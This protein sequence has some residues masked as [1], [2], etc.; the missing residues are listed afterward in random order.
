MK[1]FNARLGVLF[2]VLFSFVFPAIGFGAETVPSPGYLDLDGTRYVKIP[3]SNDFAIPAGGTMTITMR[4][5]QNFSSGKETLQSFVSTLVVNNDN[6]VGFDIYNLLSGSDF[7]TTCNFRSKSTDS[8]SY[9][10]FSAPNAN[11]LN[12][13]KKDIHIAVVFSNDEI[14]ANKS[15]VYLYSNGVLLGKGNMD[16]L[17]IPA[18]EALLIGARYL[19]ATGKDFSETEKEHFFN[20]Q[21]DEV[22]FY[23]NAL[24]QDE[25]KQ[26]MESK[27]FISGK[28]ILAAYDFSDLSDGIVRDIS[29]KEHHGKLM[30]S[31]PTYGPPSQ[32]TTQSYTVNLEQNEHADISLSVGGQPLV[33]GTKVEKGS[34]VSV[35]ATPREGYELECI[36]VN[37]V[38]IEGNTFEVEVDCTVSVS[39]KE[40]AVEKFKVEHSVEGQGTLTVKNGETSI[41]SGDEVDKGAT[42]SCVVA[43]ADGYILKSLTVNGIET[44]PDAD[45]KFT[46]EVTGNIEIKAVF[47]KTEPTVT[48]YKVT[49]EPVDHIKI[50][51]KDKKSGKVIES[52]AEVASGAEINVETLIVDSYELTGIYV[53][54]NPIVGSS[55]IVTEECV[56]KAEVKLKGAEPAKHIISILGIS[57]GSIKVYDENE[58]LI[59]RNSSVAAGTRLRVDVRPD[60]GYELDC[61]KVNDKPIE[62]NTFIVEGDCTI[63]VVIKEKTATEKFKVEY[64]TEGGGSLTVKNGEADVASGDEVEKGTTLACHV[65]AA[66]GY[67]LKTL[68]VNEVETQPDAA[69]NFTV[70]VTEAVV[71]KAVF[72][73][74]PSEFTVTIERV[75]N[76][77]ITLSAESIGGIES[78]SA[79]AEGTV[80]TVTATP[81][82][83]YEV[84]DIYV[85]DIPIQGLTFTVR[86]DCRVRA[87][88]KEKETPPVMYAV[89]VRTQ[90]NVTVTLTDKDG[91]EISP[92]TLLPKGTVVKVSAIA[93]EGYELEGIYLNNEAMVG[94]TFTVSE[95]SEVYAVAKAVEPTHFTVNFSASGNGKVSATVDGEPVLS[96]EKVESGK[97]LLVTCVP[98]DGYMLGS[99]TINSRNEPLP[100]EDIIPMTVDSDMDFVALFRER[101]NVYFKVVREFNDNVSVKFTDHVDDQLLVGS[102]L[103]E[104]ST[105]TVIPTPDEGYEVECILVNGQRLRGDTFTLRGYSRIEVKVRKIEGGTP[106]VAKYAV[107]VTER[108]NVTVRLTDDSG[109]EIAPGT[110]LPVGTL[111]TV[112]ATPAEGYELEGIYV[113]NVKLTG[114]NF[115]LTEESTVEAKV[116]MKSHA[117]V[118]YTVTV[119]EQENV[120]VTLKGEGDAPIPS[121]T[122]LSEGTVVTVTATPATGYELEGI[123]LNGEKLDGNT[124][125]VVRESE[126]KTVVK[127]TPTGKE[128]YAVKVLAQS[129]VSVRLFDESGAIIPSGT[130]VLEGTT[131]TVEV[132]PDEGYELEGLYLNDVKLDGNTFVVTGESVIKAIVR[133][134]S[135]VEPSVT[136]YVVTIVPSRNGT[137]TL[138]DE[139]GTRIESGSAVAE[140][141]L[142]LIAAVADHGYKLAAVTLNR[143]VI[144]ADRFTVTGDTE[145]GAI[146]EVDPAA[147]GDEPS[148]PEKVIV[149]YSSVGPGTVSVVSGDGDAIP[150][151][152]EVDKGS[153]ITLLCEPQAGARLAAL[154]V[155]GAEVPA[156]FDGSAEIVAGSDI[157]IRAEFAMINY[158]LTVTE[159]GRGHSAVYQAVDGAGV[160]AGDAMAGGTVIH[161]GDV[162][163]LFAVPDKGY[164]LISAAVSNNGVTTVLSLDEDFTLCA[165]GSLYRA[166][167]TEGDVMIDLRFSTVSSGLDST[168]NDGSRPRYYN[169]HGIEIPAD[170]LSPGVYIMIDGAVK[171]KILI[172]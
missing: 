138:S 145:V 166:I 35:T 76:V 170:R 150:S 31:W 89:T 99:A 24:S 172:R 163:H 34:T 81:A 70:E 126:I 97:T 162:L 3:K 115:T 18:I 96:G 27:T 125:T 113:N 87:V 105:I 85:N 143:E 55:F 94:D 36:K 59:Y 93:A 159:S 140:G 121:G 43:P 168:R 5:K 129:N 127:K 137:I 117:I 21:L 164:T 48:K 61:I 39:V 84:E 161:Y 1:L 68:S 51:L 119:V 54:E 67:K 149:S 22:R 155:T 103:Q 118:K 160:P 101:R 100:P 72:E 165:D 157:E 156:D 86:G 135:P 136:K 32:E 114:V 50:I 64:T 128:K 4:V 111:V 47:E 30:G 90:P 95:L 112:T 69:G 60:D 98:E 134:A 171:K 71:I 23:R 8:Y 52:G 147:S 25:V 102:E 28:N 131:V 41:A 14:K 19:C 133:A 154:K 146:F 49:I 40:K 108:E 79:V 45:G 37:G 107:T 44:Q 132:R 139:A 124:F 116:R 130:L 15:C 148:V 152:S 17:E 53:N 78:G 167:I 77:S 123:Y 38:V 73:K 120:T 83:G 12:G 153:E 88:V 33:P 66:D 46:V 57:N 80:V 16:K 75:E 82:D 144:A 91:N 26:D 63:S 104:G 109:N 92:G 10:F 122:Q 110:M 6:R 74:E 142:V 11:F 7:K 65:L 106:E 62:G 141:T 56:V 58:N 2:L 9:I 151:G 158:T 42:L 13:W 20:G 169:L 29:G